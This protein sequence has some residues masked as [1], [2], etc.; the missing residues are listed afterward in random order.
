ML[1]TDSRRPPEPLPA[2][3]QLP[4]GSGVILRHYDW[5]R[6][7][8]LALA[9]KL[10]RLCRRRG[11][12]LLVAG[13]GGLALAVGADGVHLPEGLGHL[14]G[15]LRRRRRNWIITQAAHGAGAVAQA[16]RQ[17]GA[18]AL[19]VSPVFPTASHPE[20]EGLGVVRFA[21]L[22]RQA[23]GGGLAVYALGDRKSTRLNSSH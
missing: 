1:L 2:A 18:D 21:A 9:I 10:A 3:A 14:A 7:Q 6:V 20:A 11:L 8:R 16:L 15:G 22:A 17:G 5:P 13:D 23:T 4:R 19:L 12:L